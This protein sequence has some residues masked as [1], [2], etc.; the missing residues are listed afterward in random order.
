ME[1][2]KFNMNYQ[3][4]EVYYQLTYPEMEMLYPKINS[5]VFVGKK[6]T[7]SRR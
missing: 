7:L 1:N 5:Y 2:E 3:K 6:S 4:G